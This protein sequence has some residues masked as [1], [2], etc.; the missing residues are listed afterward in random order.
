MQGFIYSLLEGPDYATLHD[1]KAYK[2][3]SFFKHF[4]AKDL[5]NSDK[6]Q[7]MISSLDEKLIETFKN[8]LAIP[9]EN[10]AKYGI[11]PPKNYDYLYICPPI[12]EG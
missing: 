6:R 8:E 7:F 12:K 9:R 11:Y 10:H 2:F 1:K 3:F 4:P 5:K